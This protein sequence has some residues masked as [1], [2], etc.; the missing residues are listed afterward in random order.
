MA[1]GAGKSSSSS[2]YN[3]QFFG[4]IDDVTAFK[5][6]LNPEQVAGIYGGPISAALVSPLP[7]NYVA[8]LTG[9]TLTIPATAFGAPPTGY[10]W[11]NLT[12]GGVIASGITNVLRELNASLI[13][14]N[15]PAS[16]SGDKVELFVT[17]SLGSTNWIVT[18]FTPPPPITLGYRNGILYS[19]ILQR[20]FMVDWRDA[21][22]CRQQFAWR[23]QYYLDRRA[24]N[25]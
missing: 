4:N 14:S 23:H 20:G 11:T 3:V 10:Y 5:V 12:T 15:A 17:N 7:P 22:D 24:G 16:L 21:V 6:P 19:N 1:I 18:L 8:Y 2:G 25:Q 9:G 13:I